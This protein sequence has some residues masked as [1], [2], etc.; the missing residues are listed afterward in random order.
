MINVIP[1]LVIVFLMV[2]LGVVVFELIEVA[3]GAIFLSGCILVATGFY[4]SFRSSRHSIP[5]S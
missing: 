1:F 5:N 2:G 3:F 4:I